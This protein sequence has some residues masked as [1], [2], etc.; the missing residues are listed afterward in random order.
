MRAAR[1]RVRTIEVPVDIDD[2]QEVLQKSP[3]QCA[4]PCGGDS[5]PHNTGAH[6]DTAIMSGDTLD[7]RYNHSPSA[8]PSFGRI[9][10]HK[11]LLTSTKVG[12]EG[13][14]SRLPRRF[15]ICARP[16]QSQC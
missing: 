7:L 9:L 3:E 14:D 12:I 15:P 11:A 5:H 4:A 10:S 8:L 2:G 6:R 1:A 16:L 13:N